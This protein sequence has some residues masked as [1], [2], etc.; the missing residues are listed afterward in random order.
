MMTP[1]LA[2]TGATGFVGRATLRR[3]VAAGWHI[4]A[5]TRRPQQPVDGV[6]WIAGALD[7]PDSLAELTADSEALLHIAGV[8][9]VPTRADFEAGNATATAHVVD[10]ARGAGVTRF[11]HVSS[12]AAREPGLSDYGWSKARSETIVRASGLDWTIVRPPAVFGP[13]DTEML[14]LFRMARRGIALL[15]PRGRMSAIYVEELARLLVALAADRDASIGAVY[16]PDDGKPGGWSH[17]GFARAIGH[18]VGRAHV[19][20]LAIPAALLH[21]G[22][23]LDPLVRRRAAKLTPDRARYIAHPDWVAAEG[24]CP[25]PA[26]WTPALDT[27]EALAET[28]RW[29]RREGWL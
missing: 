9:N 25:P 23:R 19:S 8:V 14:D 20:T 17:R 21:A 11:V 1:I 18:A 4:R 7:R 15:P 12:L 27:G 22:G 28:V 2:M 10:A 13:G 3:A 5:L 24:A 16:E 26:L 6:T 29:Y